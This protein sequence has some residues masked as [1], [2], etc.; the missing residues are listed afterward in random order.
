[1]LSDFTILLLEGNL[2]IGRRELFHV[3]RPDN[4][5]LHLDYFVC[6][7]DMFPTLV[8]ECE[9]EL[10]EEENAIEIPAKKVVDTSMPTPCVY[11]SYVLHEDTVGASDHC[12]ILLVV[13]I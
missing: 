5:G 10:L 3:G 4:L 7:K 1:M 13:K 2:L 11:D 9:N 12:P 6:S 8:D